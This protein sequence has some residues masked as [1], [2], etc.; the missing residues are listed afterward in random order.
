M[1]L[2]YC[3][4]YLPGSSNS[5]ASAYLVA[6]ITETGFRHV[7]QSDLKL[8]T[9]G[10]PPSSTFQS[11]GVTDRR[12]LAQGYIKLLASSDPPALA[13]QRAE[14]TSKSHGT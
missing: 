13:S 4:L 6:W 10:D 12:G 5:P 1:I 2:A 9:S 3:N 14:M 7:G 8:P 11:A